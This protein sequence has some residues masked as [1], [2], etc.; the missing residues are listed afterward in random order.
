MLYPKAIIAVISLHALSWFLFECFA[1][2]NAQRI[3]W[4]RDT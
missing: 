3:R 1:N 4:K 2:I